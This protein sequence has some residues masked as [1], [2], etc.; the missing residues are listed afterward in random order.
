MYKFKVNNLNRNI[1]E[2]GEYNNARDAYYKGVSSLRYWSRKFPQ[3]F[4]F[5]DLSEL[6]LSGCAYN[7]LLSFTLVIERK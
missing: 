3:E 1:I 4:F 2:I 7:G 6:D 5:L